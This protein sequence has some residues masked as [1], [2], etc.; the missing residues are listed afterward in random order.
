MNSKNRAIDFLKGIACIYVIFIHHM[1]PIPVNHYVL[2]VGRAA[3]PF[4]F[5][6]SGY[7]FYNEKNKYIQAV[8]KKVKYFIKLG[9]VMI[10]IYAVKGIIEECILN[11]GCIEMILA[12]EVNFWSISSFVL[13]N[14]SPFS[15]MAWYLFAVAYVYVIAGV[16]YERKRILY[17]ASPV[18]I[19]V[20]LV[21][22]TAGFIVHYQM[23]WL[24]FGLPCFMIGAFIR[25]FQLY[26]A[27]IKSKIIVVLL[28][29][30]YIWAVIEMYI[31][32]SKELYLSSLLMAV[33]GMIWAIQ[34]PDFN[35]GGYFEKI[36]NEISL[37][38]YMLQSLIFWVSFKI[39]WRIP[40][41][42]KDYLMPILGAVSTIMACFCLNKWIMTPL[43][44]R[45]Q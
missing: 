30:A 20:H 37:Y 6:V 41:P 15:G 11:N 5:M 9:F 35:R 44:K 43:K 40:M 17:I 31:N 29:I 19:I 18:L 27:Q 3:V 2:S 22:A 23:N 12:N 38:V 32:D 25:D 42:A 26:L 7:Y 24:L 13:L 28:T 4:F 33:I 1:F 21:F 14:D 36:G 34:H 45:K 8:L 39:L 16:F 10:F